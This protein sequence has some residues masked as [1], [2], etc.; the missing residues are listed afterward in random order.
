MRPPVIQSGLFPGTAAGSSISLRAQL[1]HWLSC[2][3]MDNQLSGISYT[4]RIL[5]KTTAAGGLINPPPLVQLL[6]QSPSL[7][8]ENINQHL[9]SHYLI[10]C[11]IPD[12]SRPCDAYAPHE[13]SFPKQVLT[14]DL[15]KTPCSFEEY[16]DGKEVYYFSFPSLSYKYPGSFRLLFSLVRIYPNLAEQQ[17]HFRNLAEVLSNVYGGDDGG[18]R[19]KL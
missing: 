18:F 11:S 9:R 10:Y 6:V 8:Q 3:I 4:L 5:N 19:N 7:T 14:G 1:Q 12:K 2:I 13:R 17:M 16:K 15:V